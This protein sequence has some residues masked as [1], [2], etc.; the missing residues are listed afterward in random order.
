MKQGTTKKNE[1]LAALLNNEPSEVKATESTEDYKVQKCFDGSAPE[2]DSVTRKLW[3][4]P[5]YNWAVT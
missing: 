5:R 3:Q 4:G 2:G 1:S